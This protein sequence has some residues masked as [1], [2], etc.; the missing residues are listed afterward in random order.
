MYLL[1]VLQWYNQRETHFVLIVCLEWIN[2][3]I[4]L[5]AR[6]AIPFVSLIV[7]I[8]IV[9]IPRSLAE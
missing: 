5:I 1:G 9:F 2:I 4:L 8:A 3:E 6:V 7:S